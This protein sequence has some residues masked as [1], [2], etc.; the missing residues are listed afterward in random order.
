MTFFS[1][2]IGRPQKRLN[3]KVIA[4]NIILKRACKLNGL[5]FIDNDNIFFKK[6]VWG[7]LH[8][9]DNGFK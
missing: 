4:A 3:D 5:G 9:N 6:I 7:C 8:L 1:S 2:L